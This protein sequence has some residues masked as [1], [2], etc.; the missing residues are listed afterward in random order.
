MT[1]LLRYS[2]MWG[3]II[4]EDDAENGDIDS[5][6]TLFQFETSMK[7]LSLAYQEQQNQLK[8]STTG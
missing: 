6:G 8:G 5:T 3:H 1:N 2:I 4:Y 7:E